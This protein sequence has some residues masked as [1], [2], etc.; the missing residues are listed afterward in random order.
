MNFK[1]TLEKINSKTNQ[2]LHIVSCPLLLENIEANRKQALEIH[3]LSFYSP[4]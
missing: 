3:L 4:K 1:Y 2:M